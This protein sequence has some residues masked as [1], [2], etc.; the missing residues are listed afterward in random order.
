MQA[1]TSEKG[2]LGRISRHRDT[3]YHIAWADHILAAST[4]FKAFRAKSDAGT[5]ET[6]DYFISAL[7]DSFDAGWDARGLADLAIIDKGMRERKARAIPD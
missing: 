5:Q 1:G 7:R 2:K 4:E 3:D 6:V